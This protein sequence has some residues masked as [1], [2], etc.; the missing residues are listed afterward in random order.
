[1]HT[2][3]GFPLTIQIPIFS[4]VLQAAGKS[5]DGHGQVFGSIAYFYI[6][7][8]FSPILLCTHWCSESLSGTLVHDS[9][10]QVHD[11]QVLS[12]HCQ[13]QVAHDVLCGSQTNEYAKI[14][15]AD[16]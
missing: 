16:A 5:D 15:W 13:T 14:F 10:C 8:N 12:I 1:M 6:V 4:R 2:Y 9:G 7:A 3:V 11:W